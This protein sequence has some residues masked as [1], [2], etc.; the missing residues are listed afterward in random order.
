VDADIGL[1]RGN[2]ELIGGVVISVICGIFLLAALLVFLLRRRMRTPI[3]HAESSHM[4]EASDETFAI[5]RDGQG[6]S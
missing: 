6:L 4:A 2:S 5:S 3:V 1:G